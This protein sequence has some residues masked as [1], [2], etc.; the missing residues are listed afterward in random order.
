MVHCVCTSHDSVLCQGTPAARSVVLTKLH[1]RNPRDFLNSRILQSAFVCVGQIVTTKY[2]P[3]ATNY[4]VFICYTLLVC[5]N[6]VHTVTL[7][8][9]LILFNINASAPNNCVKPAKAS[10]FWLC[11]VC[12]ALISLIPLDAAFFNT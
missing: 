12:M 5:F 1:I 10:F 2:K 7:S 11:A 3:Q 9:P 6:T 4:N 8:I